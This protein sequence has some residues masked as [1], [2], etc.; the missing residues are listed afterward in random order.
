MNGMSGW[1]NYEWRKVMSTGGE[2]RVIY[3]TNTENPLGSSALFP[4][5]GRG[6]GLKTL[7]M[8]LVKEKLT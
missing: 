4:P 6:T 7:F 2:E 8:E 1:K 3:K 5:S